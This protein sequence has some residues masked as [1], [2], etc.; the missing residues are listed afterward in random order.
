M[1]TLVA[2]AGC[3]NRTAGWTALVLNLRNTGYVVSVRFGGSQVDRFVGADEMR[4]LFVGSQQPPR[5]DFAFIDPA[6]CEQNWEIGYE[7]TGHA[8][9]LIDWRGA[10]AVSED[11]NWAGMESLI[12]APPTDLCSPGVTP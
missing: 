2:L 7:T 12:M 3:G 5:V 9:I 11:P 10:S 6:T 4:L 1:L 8:S